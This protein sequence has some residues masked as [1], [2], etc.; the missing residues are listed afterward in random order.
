MTTNELREMKDEM[1]YLGLNCDTRMNMDGNVYALYKALK[2]IGRKELADE[3]WKLYEEMEDID[4][5]EIMKAN[6]FTR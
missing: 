2:R 1:S 4:S 5:I 6:I 3:L